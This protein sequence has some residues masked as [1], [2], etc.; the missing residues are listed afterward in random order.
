MLNCLSF[1]CTFKLYMDS[2]I[3]WGIPPNY[4]DAP[5]LL[6]LFGCCCCCFFFKDKFSL[7]RASFLFVTLHVD[8]AN[9]KFTEIQPASTSQVLGLKACDSTAHLAYYFS[10][11]CWDWLSIPC[12]AAH[13]NYIC[14]DVRRTKIDHKLIREAWQ[15]PRSANCGQRQRLIKTKSVWVEKVFR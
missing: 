6:N 15:S 2:M 9:L 8:Q 4:R 1:L 7:H 3:L 13:S 12:Y 10:L 5:S 11:N 14:I